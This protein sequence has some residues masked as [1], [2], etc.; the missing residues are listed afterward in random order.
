MSASRFAEPAV[1]VKG[2]VQR[3]GSGR[4]SGAGPDESRMESGVAL[5][6]QPSR[7]RVSSAGRRISVSIVIPAF[8]EEKQ[9]SSQIQKI[10][11]LMGELEWSYEI[12]VVDD[13]STD[14]TSE[15]VHRHAVRLIRVRENR[16]YGAA[17]KRGIAAAKSDRIVIIDADGTYPCEAIPLLL[18]KSEE[19][20]MVVG[21]RVGAAAR[22]PVVRKPAKWF[23]R[24]LA[25]YLSGRRIPD[26]N[27]GLR[28]LRRSQVEHFAYLLPS[29]FSFTTSIT[30]ALLCNGYSVFYHPIDYHQRVGQSKIR[31]SDAYRFLLLILRTVVFFNPLKVFLPVGAVLF[32]GG[33]GK[34]VYDVFLWNL[35]ESAVMGLLAGLLMWAIGL[36]A[37]QIATASSQWSGPSS[38]ALPGS[39]LPMQQESRPRAGSRPR[40]ARKR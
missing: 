34:F 39:E 23:L 7:Q 29:G 1:G 6:E 40:Q 26:L 30:L 16:G 14:R 37:D 17:L 10:H 35:S 25:E 31:P 11:S 15:E 22:I 36:L 2:G 21:A 32:L 3:K 8:N 9:I 38:L 13:G 20:D 5:V 12:I 28:V 18:A 33:L 27:S 4:A 24:K 19:Y